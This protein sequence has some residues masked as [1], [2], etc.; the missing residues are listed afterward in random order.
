MVSPPGKT[1]VKLTPVNAE[2]FG[3]VSVKVKTLVPPTGMEVASKAFWMVGTVGRG[4]PVI[5][6]LSRYNVPVV[7]DGLPPY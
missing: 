4:Q 7:L 5:R 2:A 6:I 1:S 3:L